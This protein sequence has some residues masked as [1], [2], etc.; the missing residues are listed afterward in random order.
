MVSL[1]TGT[2]K[3][4]KMAPI[5]IPMRKNTIG[6]FKERGFVVSAALLVGWW[7][8]MKDRSHCLGVCFVEVSASYL[9]ILSEYLILTNASQIIKSW[10]LSQL[11]IFTSRWP[12][13]R[14]AD[15]HI[16]VMNQQIRAELDEKSSFTL[17]HDKT[18]IVQNKDDQLRGCAT[19]ILQQIA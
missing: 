2:H 7:A 17:S 1:Y 13:G 3:R 6:Q 15:R 19:V 8:F 5:G 16:W 12:I 10:E 4:D 14:K 9:C 18:R 11:N